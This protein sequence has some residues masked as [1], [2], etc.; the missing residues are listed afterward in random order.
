MVFLVSYTNKINVIQERCGEI[1]EWTG[2]HEV[3]F[4]TREDERYDVRVFESMPLYLK[5]AVIVHGEVV[6]A[7]DIY[8]L[9]EYF[10]M[11]RKLWEDQKRRQ[12][13]TNEEALKLFS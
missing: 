5:M 9:Y 12:M 4:Y 11:F 3:E 7:R 13:L 8:A 1:T 2:E 10:Y 6:H